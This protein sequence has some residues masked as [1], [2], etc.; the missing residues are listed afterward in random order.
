MNGPVIPTQLAVNRTHSDVTHKF[1]QIKIST[2][3]HTS[4][5]LPI[6]TQ[7]LPTLLNDTHPHRIIHTTHMPQIYLEGTC[8]PKSLPTLTKLMP[9][10]TQ[11]PPC[12]PQVTSQ[13]LVRC[14]MLSMVFLVLPLAF[15]ATSSLA[16]LLWGV[17]RWHF[18]H[19]VGG[20]SPRLLPWPLHIALPGR[21]LSGAITVGRS[22]CL[23]TPDT[24]STVPPSLCRKR[25]SLVRNCFRGM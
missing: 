17:Q 4:Q 11:P 14:V 16:L 1:T 8:L 25:V 15:L 9:N 3:T 10:L 18:D 7:K 23:K 19:P 21:K 5:M 6:L 2:S 12:P 24:S 20:P 22:S 13:L